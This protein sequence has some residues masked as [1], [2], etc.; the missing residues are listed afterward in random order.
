MA[1]NPLIST[2]LEERRYRFIYSPQI[3]GSSS[4][5][6]LIRGVE[7]I[8]ALPMIDDKRAVGPLISILKDG[9][10]YGALRSYAAWAIGEIGD[11]SAAKALRTCLR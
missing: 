2:A 5:G 7:S 8:I 1:V 10:V 11:K 4:K 9:A 3:A 6:D